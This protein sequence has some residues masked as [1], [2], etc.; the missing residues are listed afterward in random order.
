LRTGDGSGVVNEVLA[1]AP[2]LDTVF[3]GSSRVRQHLDPVVVDGVSGRT[4]HN[5][6]A[7]GQGLAYAVGVQ[8]L[9][10]DRAVRPMCHV[11]HLDADDLL[12]PKIERATVLSPFAGESGV[13]R[14]LRQ[15]DAWVDLK[16][17]SSLWR[18][19]SV[20][21]SMVMNAGKTGPDPGRGF[22]PRPVRDPSKP[23]RRRFDRTLDNLE[24]D[25]VDAGARVLLDQ[26]VAQ[27]HD[28]GDEVVLFT[29][30]GHEGTGDGTVL[31]P[32]RQ[33]AIALL[34]AESAR[35]G[36]RYISYDEASHAMFRSRDLFSNNA[37]LNAD[38]AA[39]FSKVLADDLSSACSR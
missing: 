34:R 30:P 38:G 20:G 37:H 32:V 36:V 5:A 4:S 10:L 25:G 39:L 3:Y 7:N 14:V 35:L 27:A 8:T 19:N 31:H 15:G 23:D 11:L 24:L 12:A 33:R 22:H 1:Q 26:F 9:V 16:V 28:H 29:S 2:Q 6:G 21:L 13:L 18:Y 17:W